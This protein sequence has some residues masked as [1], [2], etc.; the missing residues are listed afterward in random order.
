MEFLTLRSMSE[1]TRSADFIASTASIDSYGEIVEQKWHLER[2][3]R[4]PV[5]LYAHNSRE[6]PI[7]HA[8]NVRVT[9]TGLE[10]S[11]TFLS[12][13]ANPLA[14]QVWQAMKE[15][16]LRAVSVGFFPN[17]VRTEKR[18]EKDV[19]VLSDNEL[20]EISVVPIPANEDAVMRAKAAGGAVVDA[21]DDLG[22]VALRRAKERAASRA[23]RLRVVLPAPDDSDDLGAVALERARARRA[24]G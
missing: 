4:N 6:M 20:Y 11:V 2:Y 8:K 1:S 7:G 13:K 19:T 10:C 3:L 14:E 17:T 15:G 23:G 9:S 24:G 12:A 22:A 16:A 18:N 21:E 5:V